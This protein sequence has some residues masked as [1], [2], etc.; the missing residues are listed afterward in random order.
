MITI[1]SQL[2]TTTVSHHSTKSP[3]LASVILEYFW[4]F[5]VPVELSDKGCKCNTWKRKNL[6][7]SPIIKE[8]IAGEALNKEYHNLL[9]TLMVLYAKKL[10]KLRQNWENTQ[11][12]CFH[13]LDW[14]NGFQR[15]FGRII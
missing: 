8:K 14:K 4:K 5:P 1:F 15:C 6:G 9:S 2:H 7:M 13:L 10:T 11:R 12:I 3:E